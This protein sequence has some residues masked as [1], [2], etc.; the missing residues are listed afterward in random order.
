MELPQSDMPKIRLDIFEDLQLVLVPQSQSHCKHEL[1]DARISS[2]RI[3]SEHQRG[4]A[5]SISATHNARHK[6]VLWHNV[7]RHAQNVE[8]KRVYHS[9]EAT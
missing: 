7:N 6:H 4:S 3:E 8:F 5:L 1:P 2:L 9:Q